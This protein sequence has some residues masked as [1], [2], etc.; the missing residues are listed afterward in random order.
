MSDIISPNNIVP[1]DLSSS[2]STLKEIVEC[3][4]KTNYISRNKRQ[5][6]MFSK[7]ENSNTCSTSE[8]KTIN[9]ERPKIKSKINILSKSLT[10]YSTSF[11]SNSSNIQ[12]LTQI[13]GNNKINYSSI[14]NKCNLIFNF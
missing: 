1:E 12:N 11:S 3:I 10:N 5:G 4:P 14:A 7:A 6:I 13:V 9:N 8:Q 2:M